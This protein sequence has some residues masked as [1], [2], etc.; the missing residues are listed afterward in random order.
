MPP[1]QPLRRRRRARAVRLSE[2]E[3]DLMALKAEDLQR[4]LEALENKLQGGQGRGCLKDGCFSN[5]QKPP[6]ENC[7]SPLGELT[8]TYLAFS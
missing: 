7:G 4:L 5:V 8:K 2:N 1:T 3:I 6:R